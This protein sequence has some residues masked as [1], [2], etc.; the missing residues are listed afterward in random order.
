MHFP[1]PFQT[2]IQADK[3]FVPQNKCRRWYCN[4]AQRN[5]A[6]NIEKR[7]SSHPLKF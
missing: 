6:Q 4:C 2:L 1:N 5:A 7:P 3:L